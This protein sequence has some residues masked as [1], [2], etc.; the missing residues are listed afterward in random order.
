MGTVENASIID[1]GIQFSGLLMNFG[2]WRLLQGV[3]EI[4]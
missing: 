1:Y 3:D 4:V 2:Y